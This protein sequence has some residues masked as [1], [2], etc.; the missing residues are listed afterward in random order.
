MRVLV[1][2]KRV[3]APGAKI[4]ITDDGQAV[5]ATNLGH[6]MS[7]HEECA[8]ELAVQ[9]V[10]SH[11]GESHVLTLGVAE[12]DEQCRWA[13]S[14]GIDKATLV[15]VGSMDWDPQRTA[16]A[17]TESIRAIEEADGAF[18]L[19]IFGN[20]SADTGGFQV[21]IRVARSLTRPIVNGI[22]GVE[23]AEG[24]DVIE[25]RRETDNGFEVY[26]LPMPAMIGVKE[27]ITWPRYPTMRGRLASKK[28]AVDVAE[29][30]AMPGG[31]SKVRLNRPEEKVSETII[32]GE[33]A[34]AAPKVVEL[35]KE[36]GLWPE[37]ASA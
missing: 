1:C 29:S 10:E 7:P 37:G 28:L 3:P 35:L 8:L 19:V 25:A 26:R 2:V 5:D 21:G 23:I 34:D 20:E 36:L 30:D 4:N 24:S 11:G 14:I 16:R 22:K 18:D 31:Q 9:L 6:T 12:A 17:L 27:G 15:D 33:G 13:A 32:L